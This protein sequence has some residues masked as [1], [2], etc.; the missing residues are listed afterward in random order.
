MNLNTRRAGSHHRPGII[1][2][3]TRADEPSGDTLVSDYVHCL[4]DGCSQV[5][6]VRGSFPPIKEI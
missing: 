6:Y 4:L 1:I 3:A 2:S 5:D